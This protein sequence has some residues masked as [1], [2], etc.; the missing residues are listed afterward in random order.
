MYLSVRDELNDL[1]GVSDT[2]AT[3]FNE[4]GLPNPALAFSLGIMD[5]TKDLAYRG[6][7]ALY[8]TVVPRNPTKLG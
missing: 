8:R 4:G 2:Y 1:I 3:L 5:K 6:G 7:A